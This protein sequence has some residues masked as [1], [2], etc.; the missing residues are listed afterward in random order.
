MS[1]A[2]KATGPLRRVVVL[3]R[4]LKLI[5]RVIDSAAVFDAVAE[6]KVHASQL[7]PCAMR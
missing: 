7:V 1:S 4:N 2:I 6:R 5:L 3:G